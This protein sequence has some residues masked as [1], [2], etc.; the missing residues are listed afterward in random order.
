MIQAKDGAGCGLYGYK[1]TSEGVLFKLKKTALELKADYVDV[2]SVS[3][4]R[5]KGLCRWNVMTVRGTAYR[6]L[7]RPST[8]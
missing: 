3:R 8:P 6:R 2:E 1:G 7:G 4:P 5:F